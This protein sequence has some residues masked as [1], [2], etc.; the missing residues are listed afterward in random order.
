MITSDRWCENRRAVTP[1]GSFAAHLRL[2]RRGRRRLVRAARALPPG[3][4]VVLS[5]PAPMAA[6]RCRRFASRAG[7]EILHE[8][9]ALPSAASPAYLV[10]DSPASSA[11]FVQA[12]LVPPPRSIWSAPAEM[13]LMHARRRADPGRLL[14]TLAPGRIVV[15]RRR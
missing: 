8:Y 14:R 6:G 7:I 1:A 12:I 3:T 15:G 9:I 10:E 4:P 11:L 2:L 13:A 5:A